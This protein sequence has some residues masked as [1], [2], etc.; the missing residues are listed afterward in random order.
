MTPTD[1]LPPAYA[2]LEIDVAAIVANWRTL[3]AAHGGRPTAG[4]LKADAYGLGAAQVAPAL[5]AAGCR[6]FFVAHLE[7]AVAIRA[8]LPGAMLAVLNGPLPGSEP[9]YLAHEIDP[10]LGSRDDIARWS[11]L[12]RATGRALPALLHVDTG[13]ARLGLEATDLAALRDDPG[14]LAGIAPRYVLTHL[15]AADVPADPANLQQLRRFQAACACLPA[16]PR[17]IANSAGIFLGEAFRSDLA[18]PGAA[19]YGVNPTQALPNPMRPVARLRA[20]VLQVRDV[21]GG[22]CIGYNG[23]WR[24]ARPSRVAVVG[25]G[26]ADGFPRALSNRG[27]AC[28]DGAPVPLVGRVSMDLTAYDVTDLPAIGAGDWL[29]LIG[30]HRDI[31]LVAEAAGTTA[32]EILTNLGRRYRRVW[33][34]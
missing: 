19:L 4:V 17:S 33:H 11:A 20:R 22:A 7:E 30:P 25:V 10:V 15:S 28:F 32:Y 12:A 9:D 27:M 6:H 8:K 1:R 21:P 34:G 5:F 16:A 23:T 24:A 2:V 18:R 29:E 13:I 31:A 3:R 14:L 26:Y